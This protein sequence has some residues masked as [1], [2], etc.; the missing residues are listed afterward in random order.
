M[1]QPN[2]RVVGV[3]A[4]GNSGEVNMPDV[5]DDSEKPAKRPTLKSYWSL[6]SGLV[7]LFGVF[8]LLMP[9]WESVGIESVRCEV[10]SAKPDRNSGGSLGSATTA[11]VLVETREAFSLANYAVWKMPCR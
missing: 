2:P 8:F 3:Q 10:L 7:L 5:N 6:A 4:A 1:V 11:G 9:N